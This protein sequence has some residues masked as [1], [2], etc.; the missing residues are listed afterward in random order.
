MRGMRLCGH[1]CCRFHIE[2][3]P[4]RV[5]APTDSPRQGERRQGESTKGGHCD[6]TA[7]SKPG[8]VER[9]ADTDTATSSGGRL[10][11]AARPRPATADQRESR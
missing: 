3:F 10:T 1:R 11:T 7:P 6:A 5:P 4:H 9:G 2:F 8:H